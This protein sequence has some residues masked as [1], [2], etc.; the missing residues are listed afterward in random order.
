MQYQAIGGDHHASNRGKGKLA[1]GQRPDWCKNQ[2]SSEHN[3]P[4]GDRHQL[5]RAKG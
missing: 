5:T 1:S 3:A 4:E 2:A